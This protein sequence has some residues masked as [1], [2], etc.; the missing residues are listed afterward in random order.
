MGT[1]GATMRLDWPAVGS[2]ARFLDIR[3]Y[4]H[5]F[6]EGYYEA[7]GGQLVSV[8]MFVGLGVVCYLI[9]RWGASD[10]LKSQKD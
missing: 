6:T 2:I 4:S 5:A 3:N 10:D 9:A 7:F 8:L 1:I